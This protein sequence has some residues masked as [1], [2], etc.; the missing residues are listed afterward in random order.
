MESILVLVYVILIFLDVF[1]TGYFMFYF[2]E[3]E[4]KY[5]MTSGEKYEKLF[6]KSFLYGVVIIPFILTIIFIIG[7]LICEKGIDGGVN[8]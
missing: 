2:N 5:L 6:E 1:G 3:Q 7:L 8:V 4:I